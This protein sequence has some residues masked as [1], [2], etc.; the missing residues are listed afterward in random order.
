VS[1]LAQDSAHQAAHAALLHASTD[2]CV[3]GAL[4]FVDGGLKEDECWSS[5]QGPEVSFPHACM[6]ARVAPGELT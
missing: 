3:T 1:D 5:R 4:G 2:E 6:Y